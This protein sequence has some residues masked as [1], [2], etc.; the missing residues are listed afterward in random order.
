MEGSQATEQHVQGQG[1][2]MMLEN[3][4]DTKSTNKHEQDFRTKA[5][6]TQPRQLTFSAAPF[7]LNHWDGRSHP[8]LLVKFYGNSSEPNAN[9]G[10]QS[11]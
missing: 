3:T 4:I 2:R 5:T 1:E 11:Q 6:L 10:Y 9:A 7:Q 8:T